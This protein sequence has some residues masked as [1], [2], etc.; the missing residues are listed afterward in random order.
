[1]EIILNRD[2]AVKVVHELLDACQ[3]IEG[4]SLQIAPPN[5]PISGYQIIIRG[6][7]SE[8]TKQ[9]I[10]EVSSKRQLMMQTGNIWRTKRSINK[11]P[12]TII[13]YKP[14]K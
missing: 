11:E 14:K 7:L 6:T 2:E 13:I 9:L 1:L 8:K 3:D 5:T 4:C 12:D 10:Q